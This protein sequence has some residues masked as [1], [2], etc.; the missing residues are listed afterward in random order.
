[1]DS[2]AHTT[3]MDFQKVSTAVEFLSLGGNQP[4]NEPLT[5]LLLLPCDTFCLLLIPASSSH[6]PNKLIELK[7]WSRLCFG[8]RTTQI[9]TEELNA[10]LGVSRKGTLGT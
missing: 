3:Y 1:M 10:S 8:G 5:D 2:K 6:R 4:N 7:S 9:K